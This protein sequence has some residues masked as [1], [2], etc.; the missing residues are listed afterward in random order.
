MATGAVAMPSG[1][2]AA[3]ATTADASPV[4]NSTATEPATG[5]QNPTL[6]VADAETNESL[7]TV[8]VSDGDEVTLAYEHSVEKSP[9]EDIYVVDGTNLQMDRMVF[10]SYGAGLPSE[11]PVNHTDDGFVVSVDRSFES[12]HVA[13]GEIAGHVLF[14]DDE[15]FDLVELSGGSTVTLSVE[16]RKTGTGSESMGNRIDTAA[17]CGACG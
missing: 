1:G 14:V 11:A 3:T 10:S 4:T 17:G 6:L 16:D 13:P 5:P 7:L 9:I 15:C 2:G 12:V 8:P